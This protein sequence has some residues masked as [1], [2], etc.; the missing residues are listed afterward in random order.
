M[1]QPNYFVWHCE[2]EA[3][4]LEHPILSLGICTGRGGG[5]WEFHRKRERPFQV[6]II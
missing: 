4:R 5:S 3:V 1:K 2:I 6:I